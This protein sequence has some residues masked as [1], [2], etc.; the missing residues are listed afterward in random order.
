MISRLS[1]TISSIDEP[2][3]FADGQKVLAAAFDHWK[4]SGIMT[5]GSGRPANAMVSGDPNQDGDTSNDRLSGYGR[6]AFIGPDYATM[7]LRIGRKMNVGVRCHLELTAESFNV[8]NRDNQRFE[9]SD[10]GFYNSAGQFVKYTQ[11]VGGSYYPA[12]YQQPASLMKPTTSFAP[13]QM[14]FSMR[15]D[16]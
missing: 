14:Q 11:S 12:Y 13:R 9:I 3:P 4:I 5:Y 8:F 7:D 6:N 10:N 2:N 16:F 15:L 1:F